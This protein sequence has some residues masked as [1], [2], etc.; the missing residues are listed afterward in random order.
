VNSVVSFAQFA[1]MGFFKMLRIFLSGLG[2]KNRPAPDT[3]ARS[4]SKLLSCCGLRTGS[5]GR[6]GD[7]DDS[8]YE[9]IYWMVE[10]FDQLRAAKKRAAA[11]RQLSEEIELYE[12]PPHSAS[13]KLKCEHVTVVADVHCSADA[14]D[15]HDDAD[16]DGDV[17]AYDDLSDGY[18]TM[19]MM[20]MAIVMVMLI[21]M[22]TMMITVI[23]S[24]C[25]V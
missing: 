13:L 9:T 21:L 10:Y 5:T 6:Q 11:A 25:C 18:V 22:V 24:D 14:D 12:Q 20:A 2:K 3:S 1:A 8:Y 16:A 15:V 7:D 4:K 17:D 23:L 19:V